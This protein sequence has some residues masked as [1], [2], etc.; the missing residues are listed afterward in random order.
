MKSRSC[1]TYCCGSN[2]ADVAVVESLH[3]QHMCI[4]MVAFGRANLQ[5]FPAVITNL[6][7][8]ATAV[9]GQTLG[10]TRQSP[11]PVKILQNSL[12]L[13]TAVIKMHLQQQQQQ[14]QQ[15]RQKQ[16]PAA[17]AEAHSSSSSLA[18]YPAAAA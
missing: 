6:T 4:Y 15:A 8:A 13:M 5:A 11:H 17:A 1:L 16:L 10:V 9:G 18:A 7:T 2:D 3:D 14:Q 12:I